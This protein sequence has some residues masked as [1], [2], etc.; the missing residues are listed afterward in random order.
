MHWGEVVNTFTKVSRIV[1]RAWIE[2]KVLLPRGSTSSSSSSF[3]LSFSPSSSSSLSPSSFSPS[4]SSSSSSVSTSPPQAWAGKGET[5][6]EAR[7]KL[8]KFLKVACPPNPVLV[9]S[10]TLSSCPPVLLSCHHCSTQDNV[11]KRMD[12]GLYTLEDG[13]LIPEPTLTEK[14]K[15]GNKHTFKTM[16]HMKQFS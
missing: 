2:G 12:R 5:R 7:T 4:S 6:D 11:K 14:G 8:I 9:L 1:A 10:C 3:S 16:N 15:V 13:E